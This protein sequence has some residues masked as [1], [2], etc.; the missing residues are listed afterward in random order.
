MPRFVMSWPSLVTVTGWK[1]KSD[2]I[3]GG[4][5]FFTHVISHEAAKWAQQVAKSGSW[6]KR[7]SSFFDNTVE[8][9]NFH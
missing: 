9:Y 2:N 3:V 5:G 8:V 7:G 6:L 4:A 1:T